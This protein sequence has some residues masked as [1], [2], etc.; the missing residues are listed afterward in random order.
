MPF[1]TAY[2]VSD[3]VIVCVLYD[4]MPQCVDVSLEHKA[5]SIQKPESRRRSS[6]IG[7][8]DFGELVRTDTSQTQNF[9]FDIVFPP[10]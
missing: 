4:C 3:L 1:L 2:Y 6:Q 8:D 7:I 9:F 5:V 10:Q